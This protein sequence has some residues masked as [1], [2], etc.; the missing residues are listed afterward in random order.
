MIKANTKMN[1]LIEQTALYKYENTLLNI[2]N[3]CI[4]LNP[5][6]KELDGVI[7]VDLPWNRIPDELNIDYLIQE[8]GDLTGCESSCNELR[9]N[10]YIDYPE[11]NGLG[12]LKFAI[13]LQKCWAYKIK[14]DYPKH[15]FCFILAYSDE[16]ATLR[17]H[18]IREKSMFLVEDLESYEE[19]AIL[20]MTI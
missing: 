8:Y 9:L 6:F 13:Q 18:K 11:G 15:E 3:A 17:F 16:F 7:F 10:S 1:S 14:S 4:L 19:E 12:V 5:E 2:E 20:V